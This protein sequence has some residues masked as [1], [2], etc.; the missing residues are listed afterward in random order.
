MY[1]KVH[2]VSDRVR[3]K[4]Q[5]LFVAERGVSFIAYTQINLIASCRILGTA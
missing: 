2:V 3:V 4:R 1:F 5:L